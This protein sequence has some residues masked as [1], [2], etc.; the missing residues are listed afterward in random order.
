MSKVR[1]KSLIAIL[2]SASDKK[3]K[4]HTKAVNVI[5]PALTI[6][7]P[8]VKK[9]PLSSLEHLLADKFDFILQ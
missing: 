3:I 4:N 6:L 8:W 9:H 5:L 2:D 1:R 7:I